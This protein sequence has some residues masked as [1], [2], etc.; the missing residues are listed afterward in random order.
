MRAL[1]P[2]A[3][4]LLAACSQQQGQ[5]TAAAA[6]QPCAEADRTR[7]GLTPGQC[8]L[9]SSGQSL[10]VTYADLA[11]G[12]Q[13]G[14]VSVDVLGDDGQVVQTL[15]ESDVPEY[16][17]PKLQ[18]VDGDGRADILIPRVLG[19]VNF[20]WGMWISDGA[21]YRRVG[22][23]S[24]VQVE[25]TADGLIAVPARSSA[26]SWSVPYYR[27]DESGLHHL[28][29]AQ[30][31]GERMDDGSVRG[32]CSLSETPGLAELNLSARAAQQR[33]CA[34]PASQVFGP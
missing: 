1:L 12:T 16:L 22:E 10:R 6:L 17:T 13:A 20:E 24:G 15:L 14:A 33:F 5:P 27:L 4:L 28:V 19:N 26:A 30:I 3:L 7:A 34:E 11:A 21:R 23:I 29:T 18:D 9:E 32:T 8:L 31:D 2:A 25:R